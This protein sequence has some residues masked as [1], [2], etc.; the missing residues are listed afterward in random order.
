MVLI[1]GAPGTGKTTL[2]EAVG[3]RLG[4]VVFSSDEVRKDLVGLSRFEHAYA[5]PDAGIYSAEAKGRTYDELLLRAHK[6]VARGESVV[7]DAS[8]SDAA[9]RAAA[10]AVARE[11]GA[12]IVELCCEL[13]PTIARERI[14]ARMS[15]A[16]TSDATP[17][18]ADHLRAR[19]AAW[20]ESSG[21]DTAQARHLA[22]EAAVAICEDARRCFSGSPA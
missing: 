22:A 17:E 1:G 3:D 7:L 11:L 15:V 21:V 14:L 6:A 4:Y 9:E 19:F 16:N 2:A 13:D 20:P 8:W 18:I 12:S 5:A 10:R